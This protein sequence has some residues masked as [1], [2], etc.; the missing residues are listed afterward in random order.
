MMKRPLIVWYTVLPAFFF[1]AACS[2]D[3]VRTA[4]V[5]EEPAAKSE[6]PAASVGSHLMS[7]TPAT[8]DARVFFIMPADGEVVSNPLLVEFGLAG[9][10][11]RPAGDNRSNSGHHHIIIDTEL[12]PFDL[13][14]PADEHHVHFGDGSSKTELTLSPSQHTLQLLF[15]DYRHIPHNPPVFSEQITITVK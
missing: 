5:A 15:A 6:A 1:F 2:Q 8:E 4:P 3:D 10:E 12:P 11:I 7:Q 9:M 13:P 14:I